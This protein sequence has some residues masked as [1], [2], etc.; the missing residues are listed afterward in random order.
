MS[1][2]ARTAA[3]RKEMSL[4]SDPGSDKVRLGKGAG[5]IQR[6]RKAIDAMGET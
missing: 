1:V 5:E 2:K 3:G 4:F 6:V